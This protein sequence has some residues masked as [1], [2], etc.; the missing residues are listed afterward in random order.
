MQ[1]VSVREPAVAGMFYPGDASMLR[2]T[3]ERLLGPAGESGQVAPVRVL[4]APH[5]GYTYSGAI[6]AAGFRRLRSMAST[7]RRAFI[8]GP[9]H[10]ESFN[11]ISV[12]DGACYRTPLGDV[13]VDVDAAR[14]LARA[15][16]SI[17]CDRAGHVLRRGD[18]GEHAIEVE[19]PFL[20]CL[21]PAVR[22]VPITMGSQSWPACDDLAAAIRAVIDWEH[23]VLIASSDL[24]HFY[25]D[26]RAR[27]L[28]SVFC[29]S[30]VTLD[31]ALL[32]ERLARG[33]CEACGA[34][35]VV[36]SLLASDELRARACAVVASGN[37]G[38]VSGDRSSVVGYASAVITGEP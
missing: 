32:R 36:A 12:F 38:D 9:S 22:I 6:A 25:D 31:A 27:E 3:V 15:H 29:A 34:G 33:E 19:L 17:R 26:A 21:T 1:P 16:P 18:R 35:P 37:S 7:L 4:L 30:L 11:F 14:A 28:D 20:Q 2:S 8:I 5:A 13:A 23:D 10:V 24:S